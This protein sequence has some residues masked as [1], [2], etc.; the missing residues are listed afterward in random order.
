MQKKYVHV[1]IA[2]SK[3]IKRCYI[4]IPLYEK[5]IAE[6]YSFKAG[7]LFPARQCR[8]LGIKQDALISL[9]IPP[10]ENPYVRRARNQKKIFPALATDYNI[11]EREAWEVLKNYFAGDVRDKE[12]LEAIKTIKKCIE[13]RK[14]AFLQAIISAPRFN[15]PKPRKIIH[16]IKDIPALYVV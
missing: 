15:K 10:K 2:N 5:F 14:K 7:E 13:K 3:D 16:S 8:R 12:G 4:S 1:H 11:L 9:S 6:R